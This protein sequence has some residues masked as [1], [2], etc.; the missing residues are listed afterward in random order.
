[1]ASSL[2]DIETLVRQRLIEPTPR[3]WSSEELI[4]IITAGIKDLWRS[5]VDLK[6][7]HYLITNF[8]DVSYPAGATELYGVPQDVHKVYMIE[9]K[10]ATENSTNVGL[11]FQ[12]L[13]YNHPFFQQARTMDAV[14]PASTNIYYSLAGHGAPDTLTRVLVAPK[15]T[16]NMNIAFSYIA[17]LPPLEGKS[18][19]PIPGEADNALVAWTV[20]YARAKE[21]DD[22]AP[23]QTWL[24][25]YGTE[26]TNL[27]QS[28][29]IRQYQE[30]KIGD[31]LYEEYWA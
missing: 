11:R 29:G 25:I 5:I 15:I 18:Q 17:S 4:G 23:D 8:N 16:A 24:A 7:E 28:L 31:A 26:K 20:A 22:R 14:V 27:L 10:D 13:E 9:P 2:S 30:P 3:F 1:M 21:K 19:V 6:Q 12:P